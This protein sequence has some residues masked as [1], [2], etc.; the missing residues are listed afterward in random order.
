MKPKVLILYGYGINCDNETQY[1]FLLAGAQAEKVHINQL[2]SGEKRLKDFQILAIPGGFS[3]GDDIGAGKV[4]AAKI[5]YNL[6][7][8]FSEFVKVGKLIIGICNGFQVMV[9]LGI[10]PGFKKSYDRQDV[11]LTFND[12]GR[13]ED[14]WV[15]LK[16]NQKSPCIWTGGIERIYLPIRHGE[17]KFISKNKEITEK[18]IKQN[19]IV[20]QYIDE[21]GSLPRTNILVRG[22]AGYPWNPNGSELNIAGICDETGR[23]F[24][25][26]PHPEAFLFPQNY[27]KWFREKI[28]E[29]EGVKVF[30]NGVEFVKNKL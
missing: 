12:S 3:F 26:M 28:Q 15:Y 1:G 23:I 30:R 6:A 25:L 16:I 7:T 29:G 11:T 10:L 8:E 13:F 5:K 22:L 14:R 2:I 18:L 20:A 17:G 27:P 21:K 24:G 19:Q 9:K 4:L